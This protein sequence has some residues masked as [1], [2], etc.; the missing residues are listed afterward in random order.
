MILLCVNNQIAKVRAEGQRIEEETKRKE[1]QMKYIKGF[2]VN[3][4][5][6]INQMLI[7]A[8]E[9]KLDLLGQVQ[10]ED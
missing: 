9:S 6:D 8:I 5:V 2:N 10:G 4:V 7:G 3:D 1:I